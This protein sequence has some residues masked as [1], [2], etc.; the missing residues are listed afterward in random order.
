MSFDYAFDS[1]SSRKILRITIC[2]TNISG[3]ILEDLRLEVL[4][5]TS[6]VL[7]VSPNS[8]YMKDLKMNERI[9]MMI[10]LS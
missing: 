9:H 1:N 2:V 10:F 3:C 7:A 8:V 4:N 5:K 6:K